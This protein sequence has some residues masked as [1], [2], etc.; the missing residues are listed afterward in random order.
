MKIKRIDYDEWTFYIN[1]HKTDELTDKNCGK[2]LYFFNSGKDDLK[3]V[4]KICKKA[5]R[6]KVVIEVKH[7][8]EFITYFRKSGVCCF[9]CNID[10]VVTHKKIIEFFMRNDMIQ[11]KANGEYYNIAYKYE[12]QS[13]NNEYTPNFIAKIYLSMFIDLKTGQWKDDIRLPSK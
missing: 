3:F 1:I 7:T 11:R 5:I 2:W 8:R 4:E 6:E 10:D 9:Y 13:D 12:E